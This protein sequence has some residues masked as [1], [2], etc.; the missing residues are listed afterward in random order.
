MMS[1]NDVGEFV[2]EMGT[3]Q[4][5]LRNEF[6]EDVKTG[7]SEATTTMNANIEKI[8]TMIANM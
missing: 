5:E 7:T 3:A 4:T 8:M 6:K 1:T 2:K